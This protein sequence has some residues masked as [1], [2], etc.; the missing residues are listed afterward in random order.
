MHASGLFFSYDD[1]R[2]KLESW[3]AYQDRCEFDVRK[4][5]ATYRLETE[6]IEKLVSYLKDT[7]FLDNERFA[8]SFVSGKVKI[9]RWGRNKIKAELQKKR[10]SS[11]LLRNALYAIDEEIYAAN[12][13]A[14]LQKKHNSLEK[15]TDPWKKKQKVFQFLASKGYELDLIQDAYRALSND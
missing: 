3:C 1:V 14:L 12:L 11:T 15:E 6:E 5:I 4:K 9:K 10:L 7:Q 8:E 2:L 13:S